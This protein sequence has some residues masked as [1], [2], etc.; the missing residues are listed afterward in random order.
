MN[1][2]LNDLARPLMPNA[3]HVSEVIISLVKSTFTV[4]KYFPSFS[5]MHAN[6]YNSIDTDV[7][8]QFLIDLRFSIHKKGHLKVVF[9]YNIDRDQT[10]P[11]QFTRISIEDIQASSI[12]ATEYILSGM[13]TITKELKARILALTD[14]TKIKPYH[15]GPLD[16]LMTI[17]TNQSIYSPLGFVQLEYPQI[18]SEMRMLLY[19]PLSELQLGTVLLDEITKTFDISKTDN[20][21]TLF[22]ILYP[23]YVNKLVNKKELY[24]CK[25]IYTFLMDTY[26]IVRI[27]ILNTLY[28]AYN[29]P[30]PANDNILIDPTTNE[31][32]FLL[33]MLNFLEKANNKNIIAPPEEY[34]DQ[35]G[36]KTKKNTNVNSNNT[37]LKK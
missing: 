17:Y 1:V 2:I 26:N 13:I 12:E 33:K 22:F 24:I 31:D 32:P 37:T 30:T 16:L 4:D 28:I 18:I 7:H 6:K 19:T 8:G 34:C 10:M 21:N 29:M 35:P 36:K 15:S 5:Y 11:N 20:I 3:A 27:Y 9:T 25:K 23:N 14:I